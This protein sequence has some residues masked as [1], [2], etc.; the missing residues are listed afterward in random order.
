[1]SI[2]PFITRSNTDNRSRAETLY[3]GCMQV[4]EARQRDW[5]DSGVIN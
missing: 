2:Q 5:L 4:Q 1:M 3:F